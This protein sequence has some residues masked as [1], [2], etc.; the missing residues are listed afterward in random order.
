[1]ATLPSRFQASAINTRVHGTATREHSIF[2][3]IGT[4]GRPLRID[5]ADERYYP[6]QFT[7]F[8]PHGKAGGWHSQLRSTSRERAK[9]S[10][11]KWIRIQGF[12]ERRFSFLGTLRS[13]MLVDVLS[14]VEDERLR[15]HERNQHVYHRKN[16]AARR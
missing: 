2:A 13:Q 10:L 16:F 3:P 4:F 8:F 1:M 7:L 6:Y 11:L 5:A 9:L 15:F 12:T 14:H